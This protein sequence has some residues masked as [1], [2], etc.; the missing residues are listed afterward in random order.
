MKEDR[1][2]RL[3]DW[4]RE[5]ELLENAATFIPRG[6]PEERALQLASRALLFALTKH[7]EEFEKFLAEL[8]KQKASRD[9]SGISR[10]P[11]GAGD[12]S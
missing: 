2:D 9:R 4:E 12:N 6:S 10:K 11:G 5:A 7:G 3:K 1:A 8:P